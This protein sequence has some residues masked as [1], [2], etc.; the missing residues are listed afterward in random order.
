MYN[1]PL[2]PFLVL[3]DELS[4]QFSWKA[5]D[6]GSG[7]AHALLCL[8]VWRSQVYVTMSV[9]LKNLF[10]LQ[11]MRMVK[12][13]VGSKSD[14][15][16]LVG[17]QQCVIACGVVLRVLRQ[18]MSQDKR[19]LFLLK[20]VWWAETSTWELIPPDSCSWRV[21]DCGIHSF[22]HSFCKPGFQ[23]W[24]SLCSCFAV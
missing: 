13:L 14:F 23:T 2:L 7:K 4:R 5:F 16:S 21:F 24:S 12:F 18:R 15:Y 8:E 1:C 19:S 3:K 10:F 22:I 20:L 17:L 6:F 11:S 9:Y